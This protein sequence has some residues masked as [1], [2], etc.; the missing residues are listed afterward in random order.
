MF[1]HSENTEWLD[2]SLGELGDLLRPGGV[3][4]PSRE[5]YI[6]LVMQMLESSNAAVRRWAVGS[7]ARL[8]HC[9]TGDFTDETNARCISVLAARLQQD[10][11]DRLLALRSLHR[12]TEFVDVPGVLLQHVRHAVVAR[13]EDSDEEVVAWALRVLGEMVEHLSELEQANLSQQAGVVVAKLEDSASDVRTAAM[14]TLGKM[15]PATIAQHADA[16]VAMLEDS[17]R[18]V[19]YQAV[20]T[21]GR[22]E[23]ATR[24]QYADAVIKKL[25]CNDKHVREAALEALAKLEA[26]TLAQHAFAVVARLED[27]E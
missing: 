22:L 15:E 13:L 25:H 1:L 18:F 4:N 27:S 2:A 24:A 10:D 19:R 11:D 8:L 26:A 3:E 9:D 5:G 6:H 20:E 21:F 12:V 17:T 14:Q 16:V 7:I 23:P